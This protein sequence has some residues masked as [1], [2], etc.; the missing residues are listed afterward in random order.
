MRRKN[1][2]NRTFNNLFTKDIYLV[3]LSMT[4]NGLN[5][6]NFLTPIR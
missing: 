6:N 5:R 1:I 2:N 4:I 3:Y